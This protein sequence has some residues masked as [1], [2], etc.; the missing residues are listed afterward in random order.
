ML[1]A[2]AVLLLT[3][4]WLNPLASGPSPA[5]VPWLVTLTLALGLILLASLRLGTKAGTTTFVQRWAHTFA[6]A[7]LLA[8]LFSTVI[9]L[10]QYFGLAHVLSPWVN[11]TGGLGEAF[12]N[13][14]QRNQ[15]ASLTNISLVA[16]VWIILQ[17]QATGG[18]LQGD[19][20][21]LALIGLMAAGLLAIGNAIS[22]SR[23]GLLQ[24]LLICILS[25]V[26]GGWRLVWI[27]R[28]LLCAVLAYV[29]A[30]FAMPYFAGLDVFARGA[31]SRMGQDDACSSRLLLWSNVLH[32]IAQKPWLGWGWGELDYAQIGR[33]HV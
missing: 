12:A 31:L 23:T 1:S 26:W 33:A 16:L 29:V 21:K 7:W 28:L 32:L 2:A 8:G 14:R 17:T 3:L 9:G 25:G 4:P 18:S 10:L 11:Q 20:Q 24:L 15:F 30:V 27:R 13:L 22:S 5:V 6:L 19:K